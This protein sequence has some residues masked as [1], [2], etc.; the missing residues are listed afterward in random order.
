MATHTCRHDIRYSGVTPDATA[1]KSTI[2]ISLLQK[3]PREVLNHLIP[4]TYCPQPKALCQDIR[5]YSKTL[6]ILTHHYVAKFGRSIHPH[7]EATEWLSND[8]ARY[9]N[10]DIPTMYGYQPFYLAVYGRHYL[11]CHLTSEYMREYITQIDNNLYPRDIKIVV[12]LLRPKER[13]NLMTFT[14]IPDQSSEPDL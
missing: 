9:L 11:T 8:I 13:T 6:N 3:L 12:G 5:S 10:H 4:F 2:T 1:H 7:Q 14:G